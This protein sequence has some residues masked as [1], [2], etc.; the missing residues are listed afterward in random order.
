[1]NEGFLCEAMGSLVLVRLLRSPTERV[2]EECQICMLE[3][4]RD[5]G[6]KAVLYD[7]TEMEPESRIASSIDRKSTRLNSSH[8]L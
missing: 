4:M 6:S 1:M 8:R 5:S 3:A 2:L 7:L